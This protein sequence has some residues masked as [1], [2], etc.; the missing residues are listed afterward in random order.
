MSDLTAVTTLAFA[1][2]S[3]RRTFET[4]QQQLAGRLALDHPGSS[5][6]EEGEAKPEAA[7]GEVYE[8][9]RVLKGNPL[10]ATQNL[11]VDAINRSVLVFA[12]PRYRLR[13]L[14]ELWETCQ[15]PFWDAVRDWLTDV[16]AMNRD[17]PNWSSPSPP[18]CPCWPGPRSTRWWAATWTPGRSARPALPARRVGGAGAVV[19]VHRRGT[20]G[21]GPVGGARSDR[22]RQPSPAVDR[23]RGLQRHARRSVPERRRAAV[24]ETGG[25]QKQPLGRVASLRSSAYLFAALVECDEDAGLGDGAAPSSVA[26]ATAEGDLGDPRTSDWLRLC[27]GCW[28]SGTGSVISR[29]V[30]WRWRGSRP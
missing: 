15:T 28:S 7:L 13:V 25:A 2:G 10:V 8:G 6:G 22:L 30:R 14:E 24:V 5:D 4:L 23:H 1:V 29:S 20:R 12:D 17:P 16:V 19:H 3:N 9:R 11:A 27:S 21:R 26:P 18:G